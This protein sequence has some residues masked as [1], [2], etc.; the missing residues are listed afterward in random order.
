MTTTKSEQETIIRWDQEERVAHLYTT[1]AADARKWERLGYAV[2]VCTR[3]Q[4]GKARSWQA[5]GPLDAL[6]LRKLV[7]GQLAKRR[8]GRSFNSRKLALPKH[9]PVSQRHLGQGRGQSMA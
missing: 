3:A 9:Q 4:D 7:N 2:E 1:N 8:R 6:R 5:S